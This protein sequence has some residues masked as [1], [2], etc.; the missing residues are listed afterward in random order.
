MKIFQLFDRI[1]QI[2]LKG[3]EL[4]KR[5]LSFLII[6][7]ILLA[8]CT[9]QVT[10]QDPTSAV[11][12]STTTTATA[13]VTAAVSDTD[14]PTTS[15]MISAAPADT[16]EDTGH[17]SAA[18]ETVY[19]EYPGTYEEVWG[20]LERHEGGRVWGTLT[21]EQQSLVHYPKFDKNLVYWTPD[22]DSYHSID[23]CYT[24]ED[25]AVIISGTLEE[26][27]AAGKTDPCSK[28]VGD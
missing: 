4:M 24:L 6:L 28:C 23:W 14:L 25:S 21:I 19:E 12:D 8:G 7:L 9:S 1:F 18:P 3:D 11:P 27:I 26:A 17:I 10:G 16:Q 15:D 20:D 13:A 2:P 22:G 5:V